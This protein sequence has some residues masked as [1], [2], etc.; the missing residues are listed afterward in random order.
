MQVRKAVH[1]LDGQHQY[2]DRT[3]ME[4]SI[5]TEERDKWRNDVHGVANPQIEDG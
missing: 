4:E 2:V 1:G 5:G 3:S